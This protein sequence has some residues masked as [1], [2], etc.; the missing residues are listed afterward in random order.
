MNVHKSKCTITKSS[1]AE[2]KKQRA[3]K[4]KKGKKKVQFYAALFEYNLFP[5]VHLLVHYLDILIV[6]L[7]IMSSHIV[8][9]EVAILPSFTHF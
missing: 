4:E 6:T 8:Q 9:C 3:K 1:K 7:V 2:K 5:F